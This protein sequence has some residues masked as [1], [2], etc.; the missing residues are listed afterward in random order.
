MDKFSYFFIGCK[1]ARKITEVYD[2]PS[3]DLT[4]G[5]IIKKKWKETIGASKEWFDKKNNLKTA[6]DI[7]DLD[8]NEKFKDDNGN[9]LEIEVRGTR[10]DYVYK[11]K[12][13][14]YHFHL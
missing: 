6:P 14:L 5:R 10:N 7:I 2:I 3:E 9:T 11:M 13:F 4:Y 8:E 12:Q 1:S